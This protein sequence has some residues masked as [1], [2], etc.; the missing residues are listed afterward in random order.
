MSFID[1]SDHIGLLYS[2]NGR[3]Y[4]MKAL[5][6]ILQSCE[7]KQWWIKHALWWAL[8]VMLVIW[9]LKHKLESINTPKS[10]ILALIMLFSS[11]SSCHGDW[12]CYSSRDSGI[13][14]SKSSRR[15]PAATPAYKYNDWMDNKKSIKYTPK[16]VAKDREN[17]RGFVCVLLLC[18]L[19]SCVFCSN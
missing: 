16:L 12:L 6:N 11:V 15:T 14:S 9:S 5:T 8:P 18:S 2:N 17:A 13:S 19:W 1:A 3:M 10:D 4:V 7:V